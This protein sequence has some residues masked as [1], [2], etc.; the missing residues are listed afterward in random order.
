MPLLLVLVHRA[1]KIKRF[2]PCSCSHINNNKAIPILNTN[3]ILIISFIKRAQP[4]THSQQQLGSRSIIIMGK[5]NQHPVIVEGT[6]VSASPYDH[7]TTTTAVGVEHGHGGGGVGGGVGEKQA[8]RCRDPAFA[9]LLYGNVGAIAAVAA[10]YGADAFTEAIGDTTAGENSESGYS[11]TGY[12]YATFILGAI[13]MVFTG[14]TLPIMMCIPTLLIK[15][16]L[17]MMLVLSGLMMAY[18]FVSGSIIGGIIGVSKTTTTTNLCAR[19][20]GRREEGGGQG[21][22]DILLLYLSIY[23]ICNSDMLV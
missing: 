22:P 7:H 10:I 11:Y 3:I 1:P 6:A 9:F 15:V 17:L 21:F 8:T 4:H 19:G 20:N 16:S 23:I 14:I 18:M 12:M 5:S 2:S 13:A